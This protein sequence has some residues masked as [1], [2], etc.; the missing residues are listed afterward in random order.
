MNEPNAIIKNKKGEIFTVHIENL[1]IPSPEV[2][3]SGKFI[4]TSRKRPYASPHSRKAISEIVNEKPSETL[5]P[6]DRKSSDIDNNGFLDVMVEHPNSKNIL[7]KLTNFKKI[8]RCWKT[9]R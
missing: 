6:G 3:A 5:S 2:L 1:S 8:A 4:P 7:E 9:E